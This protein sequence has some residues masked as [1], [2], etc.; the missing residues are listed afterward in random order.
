MH[1]E[2]ATVRVFVNGI[3]QDPSF[4]SKTPNANGSI[5]LALDTADLDAGDE[6]IAD[7]RRGKL[8]PNGDG[9]LVTSIGNSY[10]HADTVLDL[11]LFES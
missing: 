7:A 4:P 11:S 2:A 5:D 10:A 1:L 3:L 8:M 9:R 6:I